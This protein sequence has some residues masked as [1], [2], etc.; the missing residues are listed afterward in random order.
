VATAQLPLKNRSKWPSSGLQLP[1]IQQQIAGPS[2][3]ISFISSGKQQ[4]MTT[5]IRNCHSTKFALALNTVSRNLTK[6]NKIAALIGHC[7]CAA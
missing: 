3:A 4:L 2:C 5:Q 7:A 1:M 6:V